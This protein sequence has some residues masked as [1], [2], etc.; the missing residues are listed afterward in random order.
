[1]E[2]KHIRQV[3]SIKFDGADLNALANVFEAARKWLEYGTVG[4]RAAVTMETQEDIAA[5]KMLMD[6]VFMAFDE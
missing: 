2:V 6:R 4:G 3:K 1:M 5:M